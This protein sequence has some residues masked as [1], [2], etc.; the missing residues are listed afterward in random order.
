MRYLQKRNE[1]SQAVTEVLKLGAECLIIMLEQLSAKTPGRL[2][3]NR[4]EHLVIVKQEL[5]LFFDSLRF[6]T[7]V[8]R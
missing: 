6:S 8:D 1:N 4:E 3:H 7:G 5:E 2:A